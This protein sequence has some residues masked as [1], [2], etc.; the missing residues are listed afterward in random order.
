[1]PHIRATSETISFKASCFWW[2]EVLF[3]Q[4]SKPFKN[5]WSF[6]RSIDRAEENHFQSKVLGWKFKWMNSIG[7]YSLEFFEKEIDYN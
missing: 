7:T 6:R 1:M 4:R 2:I 5:V 3:N